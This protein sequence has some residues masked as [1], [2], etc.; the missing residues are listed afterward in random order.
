MAFEAIP[1]AVL[2]VLLGLVLAAA[3]YDVRYRRIPNWL[4][5]AGVLAG[6]GLNAFLRQSWPGGLSSLWPGL[7]FSLKGFLLAF[8]IYILLYLLRAMGAGDVKLMGAVGALVGV[9]DWF[10]IFIVTAILGGVIAL[11]VVLLR[12]R[13]KKTFW[14]L[15][16]ILSEMGHARPAYVARD[17]LDVRNPKALRMPHGAIIA[18]GTL[19]FLAALAHY[20]H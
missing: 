14:N 5:A 16:F 6:L 18:I 10:G 12:G 3:A 7:W 8:G 1:R 13:L 9:T 4:T 11:I 19:F 17:E 2:V 20:P 15:G